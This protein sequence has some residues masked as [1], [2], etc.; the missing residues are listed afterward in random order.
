MAEGNFIAYYR[1][2]TNK[3]GIN[4]NGN[5]G[6]GLATRDDYFDQ[7]ISPFRVELGVSEGVLQNILKIVAYNFILHFL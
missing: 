2:S 6:T 3:Q 5:V 1:V 4:G 7:A